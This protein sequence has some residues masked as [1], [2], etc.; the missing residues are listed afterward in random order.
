MTSTQRDPDQ[1][2]P[3]HRPWGVTMLALGVLCIA[4]LNLLGLYQVLVTRDFIKSIL[5]YSP[6]LLGSIK[7]TWGVVGVVITWSLWTGRSWAPKLTRSVCLAYAVYIWIDR[8]FLQNPDGRIANNTFM[9]CA[10]FFPIL[11]AFWVLANPGVRNYFG[12][13]HEHSAG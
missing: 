13:T 7:L 1:Q 11:F 10:T 3:L 9:V 2:E 5:P 8:L 12:V 4:I 6:W